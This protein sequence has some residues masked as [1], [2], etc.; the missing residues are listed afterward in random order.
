[1]TRNQKLQKAIEHV[2]TLVEEA[3]LI[4]PSLVNP[5]DIQNKV[6]A[7]MWLGF[8]EQNPK[9]LNEANFIIISTIFFNSMMIEK[10]GM[11]EEVEGLN[12]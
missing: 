7:I 8:M 11:S 12:V 9:A 1:M 6:H 3:R 4:H 5:S 2:H 10:N